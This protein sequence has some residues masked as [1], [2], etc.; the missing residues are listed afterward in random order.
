MLHAMPA[1]SLFTSDGGGAWMPTDLARSPWSPQSLH[2]GPV[3]ALVA[4]AVEALDAP[5]PM[6][7]ARFTLELLRPVPVA[8]LRVEAT[9]IRPG[10]NVQLAEVEVQAGGSVVARARVLRIRRD[11][12]ATAAA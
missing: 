10:R 1:E 11:E 5:A 4:R 6:D 9:V 8:P 12:G 2:R 3:A 7:P